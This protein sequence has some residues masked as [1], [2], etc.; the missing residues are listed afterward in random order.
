[1]TDYIDPDPDYEPREYDGIEQDREEG[2]R[3]DARFRTPVGGC[4]IC[5]GY[6]HHQAHCPDGD[7]DDEEDL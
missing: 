1:M 3:E 6:P 2:L 4:V 7:Y 5:G